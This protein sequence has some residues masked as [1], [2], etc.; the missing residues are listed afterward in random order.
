MKNNFTRPTQ[1]IGAKTVFYLLFTLLI[2]VVGSEINAQAEC[3]GEATVLAKWDIN[4]G[5][6][7]NGE[8]N[9]A[10]ASAPIFTGGKQLCP[11]FNDG[12]GQT[13]MFTKGFGNTFNF[14]G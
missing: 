3:A 10:N 6:D 7:C 14:R 5:T 8:R 4:G 1:F 9:T 13:V 12:C 11:S 2:S